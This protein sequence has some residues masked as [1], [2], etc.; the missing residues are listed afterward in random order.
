MEAHISIDKFQQLI[1]LQI[2]DKIDLCLFTPD[3]LNPRVQYEIL[4]FVG[5]P[6]MGIQGITVISESG[7]IVTLRK[8]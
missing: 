2:G 8:E 3:S 4:A 1:R 7:N 6:G 5:D